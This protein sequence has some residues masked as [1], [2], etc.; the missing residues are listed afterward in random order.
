MKRERER[1][2]FPEWMMVVKDGVV[3]GLKE[4]GDKKSE[5]QV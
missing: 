4:A 3:S 5:V 1:E 2:G